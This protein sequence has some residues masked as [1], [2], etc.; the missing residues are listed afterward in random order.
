M[1][2][3]QDQAKHVPATMPNAGDQAFMITLDHPLSFERQLATPIS[4]R[5]ESFGRPSDLFFKVV[6]YDSPNMATLTNRRELLF[7][8][9]ELA[10]HFDEDFF[11]AFCEMEQRNSLPPLFYLSTDTFLGTGITSYVPA[12]DTTVF[13]NQGTNAFGATLMK[14]CE[15]RV[16][17]K[18]SA[19]NRITADILKLSSPNLEEDHKL[20]LFVGD[21]ILKSVKMEHSTNVCKPGTYIRDAVAM[22]KRKSRVI[23]T[24]DCVV[25]AVGTNDRVRTTEQIS[26]DLRELFHELNEIKRRRV[27][28][29][30]VLPH[31]RLNEIRKAYGSSKC[32][33]VV[34]DLLKVGL[35]RKNIPFVDP[36]DVVPAIAHP[37]RWRDSLHFSDLALRSLILAIKN[38]CQDT[39]PAAF[40]LE[41]DK[42]SRS[43]TATAVVRHSASS[44]RGFNPNFN[45]QY[46]GFNPA[47]FAPGINPGSSEYQYERAFPPL[48][49]K[50][51]AMTYFKHR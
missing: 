16:S 13:L 21:S 2:W 41:Q 25:L 35:E 24:Y 6:E 48:A 33:L 47:I 32:N 1:F 28:I 23:P 46:P 30:V 39:Y 27:D 50:R 22:L 37:S 20:C 42:P 9:T 3:F 49:A 51:Q 26:H 43:T 12:N 18:M 14:M 31:L 7:K 29:V 11:N 17:R 40:K 19:L 10:L 4:F 5:G 8:V 44:S 34:V 36:A 45:V 38:Q 15:L